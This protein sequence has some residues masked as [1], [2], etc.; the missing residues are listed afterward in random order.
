MCEKCKNGGNILDG[1]LNTTKGEVFTRLRFDL[2]NNQ[3]DM[4][5]GIMGKEKGPDEFEWTH[6][7]DIAFCPFCGRRLMITTTVSDFIDFIKSDNPVEYESGICK[8]LLIILESTISTFNTS[9]NYIMDVLTKAYGTEV[10][11]I[12]KTDEVVDIVFK[13]PDYKNMKI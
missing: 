4:Q 8:I 1:Y 9:D 5:Y 2:E 10:E 6:S 7:I 13:E 12:V 3:F 11:Y